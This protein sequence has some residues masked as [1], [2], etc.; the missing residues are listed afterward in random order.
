M[1]EIAELHRRVSD[2][3]NWR[4]DLNIARAAEGENKKHMDEQ[5][6]ALRTELRGIKEAFNRVLWLA[7][8]ALIV[9]VVGFV[10]R[11]GLA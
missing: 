6:A 1:P 11:G 3:E 10:V 8:S 4:Q 2:L 5:F 7:G 9:A